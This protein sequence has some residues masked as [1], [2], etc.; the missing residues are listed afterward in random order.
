MQGLEG[1]WSSLAQAVGFLGTE[2]VRKDWK[3]VAE[4]MMQARWAPKSPVLEKKEQELP[5][6]G[7]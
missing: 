7:G 4:E 2:V 3:A 1:Q 5:H 6:S